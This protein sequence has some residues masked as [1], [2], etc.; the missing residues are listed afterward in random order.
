M[1]DGRDVMA[2]LE[3]V[4]HIG[5]SLQLIVVCSI[6]TSRRRRRRLLGCGLWGTI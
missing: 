3:L 2:Q 5:R 4:V 1:G 6:K